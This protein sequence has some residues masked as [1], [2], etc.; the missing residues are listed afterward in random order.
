MALKR[1]QN[2]TELTSNLN[3]SRRTTNLVLVVIVFITL[4]ALQYFSH[5]ASPEQ[6]YHDAK[7]YY[8]IGLSL[9]SSGYYSLEGISTDFRGYL[10]PTFLGL[11]SFIDASLGISFSFKILSSILLAVLITVFLNM[12]RDLFG[13][14]LNQSASIIIRSIVVFGLTLLFFYGLAIYPL[15]D[16]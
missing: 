6:Y 5:I 15:T 11:C 14:Y 4:L 8:N 1:T 2:L 3:M 7:D 10:F 13:H 9:F 12:C 16:L